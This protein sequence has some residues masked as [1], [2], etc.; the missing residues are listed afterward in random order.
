MGLVVRIERIPVYP[1]VS[2]GGLF[3]ESGRTPAR[4]NPSAGKPEV[5]KARLLRCARRG[6]LHGTQHP[7][8]KLLLIAIFVPGSRSGRTV[9]VEGRKNSRVCLHVKTLR[10]VGA[11]GNFDDCGPPPPLQCKGRNWNDD[12]RPPAN[13][14]IEAVMRNNRGTTSRLPGA[15]SRDQIRPVDLSAPHFDSPVV[16]R[17]SMP[18]ASSLASR[19][20]SVP[21]V[22]AAYA[23]IASC[24]AFRS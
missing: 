19:S 5:V 3:R 22:S 6:T 1:L 2:A 9:L 18:A 15:R 16:M 14:L 24:R 12:D 10:A 21:A 13:S 11:G 17:C 8:W 20:R 23:A 7:F 4:T